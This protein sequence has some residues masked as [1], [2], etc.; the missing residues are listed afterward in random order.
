MI[1]TIKRASTCALVATTI[2]TL[3]SAAGSSAAA[4]HAPPAST[5]AEQN[6]PIP[7]V[8]PLGFD[9][10]PQVQADDAIQAVPDQVVPET[11]AESHVPSAVAS[12]SLEDLVAVQSQTGELPRELK[13]LAGAIY[14]EARSES[15]EGQLAVGRVIVARTKSGRFPASY[16]GV[17]YQPS[18]FSF[19]H[20]A[21]MPSINAQ[22]HLW[23]NAVALAR[24][25]DAGSWQ[26]PAEGALFF[27]AARVTTNWRV[28]RVAQIDHHIF[29]R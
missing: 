28:K 21:A 29:Y 14:F 19:I 22:S 7:A 4:E 13:C 5:L 25:S 26:S 1:R 12:A 15:L 20:G 3:F 11:S 24:I 6:S 18:Q 16:C 9:V 2:I 10:Q 17:V 27:H 8:R 23:Q